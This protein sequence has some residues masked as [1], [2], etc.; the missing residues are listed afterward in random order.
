[1][2]NSDRRARKTKKAL[3]DGLVELLLEKELHKITVRELTDHVD[4]NRATLYTHYQDIYD[5]YAQLENAVVEEFRN[6]LDGQNY[7][8]MHRLVIHY[9]HE[10]P[11]ISKLLLNKKLGFYERLSK[12]IET[13]CTEF[14]MLETGLTEI[15]DE[16]RYFAV[17]HV[18]GWLGII[19]QW[20]RDDFAHPKERLIASIEIIDVYVKAFFE[21]LNANLD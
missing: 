6:I 4:V 1:M 10:H 19:C 20:V 2:N 15:P 13:K 12:F 18:Q 7:G 16:L 8:D 3:Q 21:G 9:A 14:I 5:L 11:Q 17:Y